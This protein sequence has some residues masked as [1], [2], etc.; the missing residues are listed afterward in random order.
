VSVTHPQSSTL[1]RR[2]TDEMI[3]TKARC[4]QCMQTTVTNPHYTY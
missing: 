2:L 4:S 1:Q 3:K